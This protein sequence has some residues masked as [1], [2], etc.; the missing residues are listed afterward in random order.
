MW[1]ISHRQIHCAALALAALA[2]CSRIGDGADGGG[3]AIGL[4]PADAAAGPDAP[5]S[6][7]GG[8]EPIESLVV[9]T[10]GTEVPTATSLASGT[11]YRLEV[12]GTFKWGNCDATNC[13]GGATCSYERYGDAYYRSDDCWTSTTAGFAYIS[14]Y[15][16]GQQVD[17]GPYS[18]DHVYSIELPGTG[19]PFA[20]K[21]MDCD[22]CYL[23][24][25]GSLEVDVYVMPGG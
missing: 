22:N 7:D 9:P 21:V 23:D 5:A 17:W 12:S 20:L 24:N 25:S 6:P 11:T 14:L 18:P 4:P 3:D 19:N 8:A 2:A 15:I 10:D 1:S 16:D 13:P